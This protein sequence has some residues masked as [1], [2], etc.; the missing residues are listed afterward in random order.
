MSENQECWSG[1][2]RRKPSP[3]IE[4]INAEMRD[5]KHTLSQLSE[6]I[7][8][9]VARSDDIAPALQELVSLWRASK[10]LGL[11]CTGIAAAAAS[12]WAAYLWARDHVRL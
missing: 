6:V 4:H 10:I 11:L 1:Y 9:H 8:L 7:N 3:E 2:E 12:L 5:I